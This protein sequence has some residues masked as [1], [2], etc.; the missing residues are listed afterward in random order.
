[1]LP[2]KIKEKISEIGTDF[3]E[4]ESESINLL[5]GFKVLKLTEGFSEFKHLKR[6]DYSFRLVLASMIY[7]VTSGSKTSVLR[8]LC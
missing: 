4:N 1:M 8:C 2:D 7:A 5:K 3:N 6:N